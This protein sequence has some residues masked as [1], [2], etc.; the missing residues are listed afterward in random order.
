VQNLRT[1]KAILRSIWN[2]CQAANPATS[3]LTALEAQSSL[4]L[5]LVQT[6]GVKSTGSGQQHTVVDEAIGS[7][8]QQILEMIEWLIETFNNARND[9]WFIQWVTQS[10]QVIQSAWKTVFYYGWQNNPEFWLWVKTTNPA[11]PT[12]QAIYDRM[13]YIYLRVMTGYTDNW[14][15][16]GK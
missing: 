7:T 9:L 11:A 3:L 5:P 13:T 12:D 8:P 4:Q 6:G 16:L 15:Y 1:A 2:A 14:M 10:G